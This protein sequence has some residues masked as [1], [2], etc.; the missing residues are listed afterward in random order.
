MKRF[1]YRSWT[2][3]SRTSHFR[4]R[5]DQHPGVVDRRDAL[6]EPPKNS[7]TLILSRAYPA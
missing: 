4:T 1:D 6:L 2:V 5:I 3:R 7:T